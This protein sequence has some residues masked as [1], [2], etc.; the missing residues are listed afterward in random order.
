[1]RSFPCTVYNE[2]WRQF[3]LIT[4]AAVVLTLGCAVPTLAQ[5]T[6]NGANPDPRYG[7]GLGYGLG[8]DP[9]DAEHFVLATGFALFDYEAIWPHAAPEALRFKTEVAL[10]GTTQSS[11]ELIAS[12]SGLALY[13]LDGL[14]TPTI[15]PYVEAGVGVIYTGHK[16][17]GQGSSLNFNP[18][19]GLGIEFSGPTKMPTWVSLRL[20]HISNAG[21]HRDNRGVNSVLLQAGWYLN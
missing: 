12:V 19:V 16:V 8:Y 13:Y 14:R 11:P 7:L 2:L 6:E 3:A 21:L 10:G 17:A 4:M 5:H 9:E 18:Q 1:M 20:H 15:R